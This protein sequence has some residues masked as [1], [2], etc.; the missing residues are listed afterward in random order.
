MGD[1]T[2]AR[3]G[4]RVEVDVD[5]LRDNAAAVVAHVG[6]HAGVM[7]MVKAN[8]YGH[9]LGLAADAAVSGGARCLG[10]VSGA[11]A[12]AVVDRGVP[13]LVVNRAEPE[14]LVDLVSAGVDLTVFDV[15]LV[16]ALADAARHAGAV[17]RVH[18]KLDTGM[19]RLGVRA[20]ERGAL[21][22]RLDTHRDSLH[23]AGVFT[24]F[25][26]AEADDLGF[27]REQHARFEAALPEV[28]AL[29]PEVL[30]HCSNSGAILRCPELHHDLVRLGI[31]LYGYPPPSA[32]NALGLRPA[33]TMVAPVAQVKTVLAGDTVG[34]ART[35]TASRPSRIAT[36]AAGYADGVL[37]GQSNVGRVLVHATR[38]PIVGRVSMDQI[39]VDV[40]DVPT[41]VGP[42]DD[43]ALFGTQGDVTL[44]AD[45]VGAAVGTIPHE[46]ICAVPDRIPRVAVRA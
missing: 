5:A 46:V 15:E 11:D 34:Y 40:T 37:R 8:G 45:E 17:A 31:A 33:M 22:D 25:A 2:I 24:H 42:G 32:G 43:V 35:W 44:G 16:D 18:V 23:V 39:T 10:V 9:G 12:L 36:V 21:L 41:T 6:P 30:V 7:A 4:K 3:T 20:E 26:D 1:A 19:G 13:V 29:N 27:T 28:R 38:C 14:L